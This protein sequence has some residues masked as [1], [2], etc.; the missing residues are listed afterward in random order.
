MGGS[1]NYLELLFL[2]ANETKQ[3]QMDK[4]LLLILFAKI[5]LMMETD[6]LLR[7]ANWIQTMFVLIALHETQDVNHFVQELLYACLRK[8]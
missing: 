3:T 8:Q 5:W 4:Y 1:W 7:F 2:N 6:R